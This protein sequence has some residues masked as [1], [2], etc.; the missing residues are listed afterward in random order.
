MLPVIAFVLATGFTQ[1]NGN[2]IWITI[3]GIANENAC[4]ALA[5][6]MGAIKHACHQYEMATPHTDVADAV[7][8]EL[9]D[10]GI[11]R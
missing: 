7:Q 9:Q 10:S 11:V 6:K 4:H 3:P 1:P 2:V 5:L 8:D